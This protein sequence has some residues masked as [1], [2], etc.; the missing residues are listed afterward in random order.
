MGKIDFPISNIIP[1]IAIRDSTSAILMRNQQAHF[2]QLMD[3]IR[4]GVDK[5]LSWMDHTCPLPDNARI[6]ITEMC[7]SRCLT[8][9]FWKIKNEVQ[10]DTKT[11]KDILQQIRSVGISSIEFVGGEPTIRPDLPDLI[12]NAN[13]LGYASILVS[14]NG[15]LLNDVYI[16]ELIG[17]GVNGFHIS[18]DGLRDTYNY[19]R[20]V[21][22]F[23][24]VLSAISSI[25]K[26][27]IPVLV[28]T[29]L[30]RQVIDEL[31]A[32]VDL[33]HDLGARWG[34]N[35]IENLKYGFAGVNL[36]KLSI[37]SNDDIDKVIS[38]LSRI[39][40]RYPSTCVLR[41]TDILYIKDYLY[42]PQR[43]SEVPCSLGF[44]DI[45]LDPR[46]NVYSACMSMNAVGNVLDTPLVEIVQSRQMKSNLKAMLLR[47]CG[48]CTC[49]YSQRAELMH[50]KAS[51]E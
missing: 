17:C 25:V 27:G 37:S 38:I 22:W 24:K 48:G 15:F 10:L 33:V 28:L 42:D 6:Y 29:N 5:E 50:K 1:N 3:S 44:R 30:T 8:C 40:K 36:N 39:K 32:L 12:R 43:E 19:V 21:D 9:N 11:W 47:Q 20:G 4:K 34:V 2:Q 18:L 45:Y 23:E 46:G 51:H 49:G 14:S 7:N 13:E 35:I 41:D 26:A 16:K 31:E